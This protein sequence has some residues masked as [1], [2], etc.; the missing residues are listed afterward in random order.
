[1]R[2]IEGGWTCSWSA[3]SRG[4]KGPCRS[5]VANAAVWVRVRSWSARSVRS[6][7]LS[8]IT[9]TRIVL[10]SSAVRVIV[11]MTPSVPRCRYFR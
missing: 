9:D 8:R 4:V 2:V 1:M 3:S 6:R 10:A 5:S 11:G 7:R